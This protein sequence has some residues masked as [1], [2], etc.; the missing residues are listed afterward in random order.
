MGLDVLLEVILC[1][2]GR[3]CGVGAGQAT[4]SLITRPWATVALGGC[5]VHKYVEWPI[6]GP[7]VVAYSI[8]SSEIREKGT[9]TVKDRHWSKTNDKAKL[10]ICST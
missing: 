5:G 4:Q 1:L 8:L 9:G 2:P 6:P 10:I 3:D 7:Q